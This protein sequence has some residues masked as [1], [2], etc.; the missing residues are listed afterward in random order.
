MRKTNNSLAAALAP[1]PA[2][3]VTLE[4]LSPR[5]RAFIVAYLENV[6]AGHMGQGSAPDAVQAAGISV[7]NRKAARVRAWELMRD[8]E[9][10]AVLRDELTKKLAAG[11]AIG[12]AVIVDL[13]LNA[14]SE[15][16]KLQAASQLVDRSPIGPVI[17]KSASVN[18]GVPMEAWL[19]RLDAEDAR[20]PIRTEQAYGGDV[21]EGEAIDVADDEDI[22]ADITDAEFSPAVSIRER[23]AA[24]VQD[25]KAEAPGED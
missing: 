15:Q 2:D 14:K 17:S 18:V 7:D 9:V 19:E 20:A 12:I 11:A 10:L 5:K 8:P 23:W 6:D 24:Q 22:A 21:I 13:A 3:T 4:Q 1:L 25:A 16:V